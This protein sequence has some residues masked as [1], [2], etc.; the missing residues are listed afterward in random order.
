MSS[1]RRDYEH[2]YVEAQTNVKRLAQQDHRFANHRLALFG[3]I[4]AVGWAAWG[5]GMS[6]GWFVLAPVA[7]FAAPIVVHAGREADQPGGW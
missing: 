1:A 2:S 7:A 6:S 4:I 3:L 5:G